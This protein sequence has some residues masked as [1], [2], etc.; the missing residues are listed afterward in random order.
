MV[1]HRSFYVLLNLSGNY[2]SIGFCTV[3]SKF[4]RKEN[5]WKWYDGA[6]EMVLRFVAAM[7]TVGGSFSLCHFVWE[8]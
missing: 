7:F 3:S 2:L 8:W 6:N 1:D 4:R 5:G